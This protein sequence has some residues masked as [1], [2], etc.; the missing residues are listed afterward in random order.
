MVGE[1]GLELLAGDVGKLGFGDEGF[2]FGADELL[3]ED[4]DAGRVGLLVFELSDLVGD[5]LLAV[6]AGLDG[7]FDV[8]DALDG[9]AVLVVAVDKLVF[10]LANFVDQDTEFVGDIG[11]IVIACLAPDGQLLL[12]TV[13]GL[14]TT[15]VTRSRR[16]ATSILSRPTSSM[17]RITFFSIFTSCES[18]FAKSGPK[19]PAVCLRNA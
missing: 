6:A 3:L 10:E 11:D 12:Q 13:S 17:L 16:T 14:F 4:D 9:N 15:T 19:A 2:G 7:S 5:L 8:A 1:G 18:F